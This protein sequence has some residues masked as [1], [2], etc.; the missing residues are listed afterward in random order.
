MNSV[1]TLNTDISTQVNESDYKGASKKAIQHHYDVSN[2][3]YQLWLDSTLTYSSALWEENEGDE[4]LKL[5][6]LRKLDFY[7]T[8]ARAKKTQRVLEIGCGWGALSKRL[9]E[10]SGVQK[11]TALT[12][13]KAQLKYIKSWQNPQINVRLENWFDHLPQQPYDAIIS[14]G[15]LEAAAKLG[16]S[17]A[18]KIEAYRKFF[19][20]CHKWLKPSGYISLQTIVYENSQQEDFNQFVAEEIFPESDLPHLGEIVKASEKIFE[21]VALRNDREHYERTLK[22]WLKNLKAKRKEAVNLVGE[23]VVARYIKYLN[24]FIIGFHTGSMNL[25][26][27]TLRRIDN[28]RK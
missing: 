13:S 24:F 22:I 7:I 19:Q 15:A 18:E 1:N 25:S 4:N 27:I 3:F 10:V 17:E 8:Q 26:R 5:A 6:Q 11:V 20:C 21:I 16:L 28:P 9:V 12:L 23:K 2:D 14:I